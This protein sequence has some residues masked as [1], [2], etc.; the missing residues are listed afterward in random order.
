MKVIK[1]TTALTT[2]GS[3]TRASVAYY[4]NSSKVM[5]EAAID[6]VRFNYNPDTSKYEGVIIESASTNLL[7]NS[8]TLSTQTVAVDNA[9]VYTISFYD[10]GTITLSGA[11]SGSL[12]GTGTHKIRTLTFTTTSPSLTV[13]VSGTVK[14]A[15]LEKA[16]KHSSWIKTLG[17]A[18]TRSAEVVTGSGLLYTSV[19]DATATYA[20]GTPYALA[21]RVKYAGKIWESLQNTNTGHTPNTSPTWWVE[22][23]PDNMHAAFDNQINTVSTS[24]T[25][26]TFVVKVGSIDSVALINMQAIIANLVM[27]DP[28]EGIVAQKLAGLSGLEVYDWY[29]YFYYDPI[30][31]RT[32]VVFSDL[33]SY[34][35]AYITINLQG[36]PGDSISLALAAFGLIETLGG[37][38]YGATSGIIDY[39]VKT[40]DEF[41]VATFVKRNF[42]KRLSAQ[43][44]VDNQKLNR[45]SR[46]LTDLRATPAVWIG[47][48][49]P[50][51][52]E[53]LVVYGF[54][55]EFSF[56]IAYPNHTLCSLE[57]EGLT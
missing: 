32:Q 53:P 3:I 57:I 11:Y 7:L 56:D 26:M 49:D 55:K 33:P 34:S 21:A 54:Y 50:R 52:E 20:A 6:E 46:F 9:A 23:G 41:G 39:S 45:V 25:F 1:P 10:T 18:V 16:S 13:T 29:Q 35:N 47:S 8:E 42:S 22:V 30:L 17:T 5:T 24:T 37:T 31:K 43:L 19:T 44:F 38:Q 27:L 48:D 14:Y 4:W 28:V 51:L 36:D 15:Q 40:T 2:D 12:V